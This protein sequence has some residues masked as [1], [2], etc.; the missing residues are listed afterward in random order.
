M[1]SMEIVPKKSKI[2]EVVHN[3]Y[4]EIGSAANLFFELAH[5]L[6]NRYYKIRVLTMLP[7]HYN[8]ADVKTIKQFEFKLY[9]NERINSFDVVRVKA[10]PAPKDSTIFRGMEHFISAI[11]LFVVGLFSPRQDFF[12][13]YSPP[14]PLAVSIILLSKIKRCKCIVNIQDL[15]PQTVID[16]GMLKSNFLIFLFK[17]MESW[18]Y[19][20]SDFLTVHSDKNREYVIK[21]GGSDEKTKTIYNWAD[22]TLILPERSSV[23]ENVNLNNKFVV[24]YAGVLA[25]H[26]GLEVIL[27]AAKQL[28][29]N[30]DILFLLVGDGYAK[31]KLIKK[32]K[33]LNLN[34]VVFLPFQPKEKYFQVLACSDISLV[35][36][37]KDVVTPVIPG[38][39]ISI[40]ASSRTVVA[41]V[42][43]ENDTGAI[44]KE[45]NCGIVTE[46]G[47]GIALAHAITYLYQ[48]PDELTKL[49]LNGRRFAEEN[50]SLKSAMT[51]YEEIFSLLG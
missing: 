37:S 9:N 42:P 26:Q 40:M 15:Y 28:E 12:I 41:S 20:Q 25:V 50:F 32:A 1:N 36:L 23:F 51:K 10:F 17:K 22:T 11:Q 44:I 7:R 46:S 49:G 43:L 30:N 48:N 31:E 29:K 45:A 21:H 33:D 19:Q 39:L 18:V 47:D 24:S 4:P 27:D 6:S 16:V 3:F 2:T 5:E 34:N 14:L 38:K 13:V 35:C 8:V